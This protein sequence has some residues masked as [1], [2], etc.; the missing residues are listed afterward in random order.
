MNK[1]DYSPG[2]RWYLLEDDSLE[3]FTCIDHAG[4]SVILSAKQWH[5]HILVNHP[6]MDGLINRVEWSV[7]RPDLVSKDRVNP[8]R[9]CYYL[10]Y[11]TPGAM[12]LV[13]KT[14]VH[15]DDSVMRQFSR[16]FRYHHLANAPVQPWGGSSMAMTYLG[17]TGLQIDRGKAAVGDAVAN[18]DAVADALSFWLSGDSRPHLTEPA[19]AFVS[20]LFDIE[21][22]R[23]RGI[24]ID[25]FLAFAIY[26][27]P[28][29]LPLVTFLDLVPRERGD[30]ELLNERLV[31]QAR[32]YDESNAQEAKQILR[33]IIDVTGGFDPGAIPDRLM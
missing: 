28:D 8:R 20:V 26:E 7:S 19:N 30:T 18:H 10:D 29:L 13:I 9:E 32:T 2:T 15:F 23:A 1:G 6:E 31:R 22:G 12:S 27:Y 33:H 14:V 4:R 25:N 21:T 24:R 11:M 3:I 16:R 5:D 17:Q